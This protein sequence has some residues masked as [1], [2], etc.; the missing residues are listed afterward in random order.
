MG[1]L[2]Q[3]FPDPGIALA[4]PALQMSFEWAAPDLAVSQRDYPYLPALWNAGFYLCLTCS[5]RQ[6]TRCRPLAALFCVWLEWGQRLRRSDQH[7]SVGHRFPVT[8][9]GAQRSP[10]PTASSNYEDQTSQL[11]FVYRIRA[12]ATVAAN[13]PSGPPDLLRKEVCQ[14]L[15]HVCDSAFRTATRYDASLERI[16]EPYHR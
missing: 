3:Q 16:A 9:K 1:P 12:G 6:K 5:R 4:H 11:G 8:G 14:R 10:T 7:C 2:A 15:D 13:V